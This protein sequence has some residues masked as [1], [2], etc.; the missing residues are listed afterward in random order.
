MMDTTV[1]SPSH[2]HTH[3]IEVLQ[4]RY[5]PAP[6]PFI[7]HQ[8][9]PSETIGSLRERAKTFFEV[10]DTTLPNGDRILFY[11]IFGRERLEN[12]STTVAS[13]VGDDPSPHFRLVKQLIQG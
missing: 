11:L 2:D 5:A 7:D 9:D 1:V 10:T 6:K 4:V 12:D 8:P 13:V 3:R